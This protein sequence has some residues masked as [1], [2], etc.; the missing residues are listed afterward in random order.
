MCSG[1]SQTSILLTSTSW[2]MKMT[3]MSH[4]WYPACF[5]NSYSFFFFSTCLMSYFKRPIHK[6]RNSACY[7]LVKAN[8]FSISLLEVLG[9]RFSDCFFFMIPIYLS[10]FSVILWIVFLYCIC[11]ILHLTEF[12]K[13]LFWILYHT[14][15]TFPFV[16][17]FWRINCTPLGCHTSLNSSCFFCFYIDI[18]HI[19]CNS[20]LLQFHGVAFLG[21]PLFRSDVRSWCFGF[22]YIWAQKHSLCV[23]C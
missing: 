13:I 4:H 10:D 6:L 22:D 5:L 19:W 20:C 1:W 7:C 9:S 8:I 11:I 14:F 18:L 2:L 17:Y 16:I 21:K 3:D 15:Y 23:V 12:P